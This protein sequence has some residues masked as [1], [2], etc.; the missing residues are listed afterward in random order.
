MDPVREKRGNVIPD[1]FFISSA[2]GKKMGSSFQKAFS[3]DEFWLLC[4]A[5]LPDAFFFY[6]VSAVT[7][8]LSEKHRMFYVLRKEASV[9]Q[10]GASVTQYEGRRRLWCTIRQKWCDGT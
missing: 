7:E 9:T 3:P 4:P 2:Y 5:A 6:A 8:V 10:Y 1:A